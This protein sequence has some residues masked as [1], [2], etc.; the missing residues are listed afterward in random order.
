MD[1]AVRAIDINP[2]GNIYLQAGSV[3]GDFVLVSQNA[4][5]DSF[6]Q[7]SVTGTTMALEIEQ[8]KSKCI[9]TW[10]NGRI[11]GDLHVYDYH[12]EGGTELPTWKE[13]DTVIHKRH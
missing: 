10:R 4:S 6:S 1:R 8:H 3:F 11:S 5:V 12:F 2:G 7:L 13:E 9:E